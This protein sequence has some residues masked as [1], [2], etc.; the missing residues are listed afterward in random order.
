MNMVLAKKITG[1]AI[2]WKI[3]VLGLITVIFIIR[4]GYIGIRGEVDRNYITSAEYDFSEYTTVPCNNLSQTFVSGE[5]YLNSLELYFV[6]IAED[7]IGAITVS[8]YNDDNL[9]YQADIALAGINN[10]EWKR[11]LVN[12]RMRDDA[13]YKIVLN[14]NSDCSQIPELFVV[15]KGYASEICGSYNADALIDGNIAIN[16]GYLQFPEYID[17]LIMIS[18]WTLLYAVVFFTIW[19]IEKILLEISMIRGRIVKRVNFGIYACAIEMLCCLLLLNCSGIEFQELTKI[20]FYAVSLLASV[21]YIDSKEFVEKIFYEKR[22]KVLLY[23]LYFYAAFTLVGQRILIYPLI[24]KPTLEGIFIYFCTVR[25]FVPVINGLLYYLDYAG[26]RI[27]KKSC[28]KIWQFIGVNLAILILPGL[29]HLFAYNP[30]ISSPDTYAAM[31]TNAKHLHGM[32]DWHPAFYCMILRVIESVWDSTYAVI[33]MQY[34]LWAYVMIE[35]FC[36]LRKK[37][38][39]DAAIFCVALF[40]GFNAGN[41]V[42]INTIWKDIP[43]TLSLV[44][45]FVITAKLSIDFEEYRSKRFIY[46]EL[47]V[48]LIGVFFYRKNGVVSF[49]IVAVTLAVALR[50]NTRLLVSLALSIA[51]I[52]IIKGPVYNY[53]DIQDTGRRGMYIGLGQDILGVYY[54]GGEVSE[55]TL[56]MITMMTGY[57]NAEYNYTPTWSKQAYDIDVELSEFILNYIDTFVKNPIIMSRAI[58]DREDALWDIY[59]GQDSILG[60]VNY[61]GTQDEVIREYGDWNN[62]YSKRVYRSLQGLMSSAVAYTASAQWLSAIEWRGGLFCLLGTVSTIYIFVR[63]GG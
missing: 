53:F 21:N 28:L 32:Y 23:I 18:F 19:N 36:F 30:G 38:V 41:F 61:T 33:G 26:K 44:W 2:N 42:H 37:G 17:K 16:Y 10:A 55:K 8:I 46:L 43:Y 14:A 12:M 15:K 31:I 49:V 47:I 40:S 3:V 20:I 9:L 45:V 5:D 48:S 57:N 34:F 51:V 13:E 22:K 59:L 50:K 54:S 29:Y 52:G 24:L 6:N 7:R 27:F 62:Y 11:I 60:C 56:Q 39:S 25:W 58:I 35:F 4:I 63:G 1:W